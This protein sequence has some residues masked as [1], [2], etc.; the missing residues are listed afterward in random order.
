MKTLTKLA[1]G[2]NIVILL[3]L[4][5]LANLVVVPAIY[6]KFQTLDTLIS[7]TPHEAY[8]LI[9]SYGDQ[10]RQTYLLIELTLDLVYPFISALMFSL[11]ILYSF[12]RALPAH[13]WTYKLAL[14]PF[15][16]M[17]ADYIENACIVTMLLAYPR[18]LPGIARLSNALTVAK[19]ALT[20]VELIFVVGLLVWFIQSLRR[21]RQLKGAH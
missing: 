9:T 5:L 12:Q 8:Q 3:L 14:L 16:V 21:G 10:G 19:L 6:P 1:T 17:I 15:A 20:P 2:R 7:Y 11:A 18:L 4:F 13:P